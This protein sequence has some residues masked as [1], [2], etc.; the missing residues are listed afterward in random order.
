[1]PDSNIILASASKSRAMLLTGAGLD[2][3]IHPADIDEMEI[4]ENFRRKGADITATAAALARQKAEKISRQWPEA[5][6]IGADQMLDCG[7]NWLDKPTDMAGAA[8][9][10]RLLRGTQ[11]E[12]VTSVSIVKS[13][14]EVWHQTD[15]GRLVMRKF[16]DAFLA[17]YLE[18]IGE[19]VLSSVGAYQLEGLGAQLFE[20]I[21]GDYF[22]ILGLQVLPV[23]EYLR[24]EGVIMV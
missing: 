13:E 18:R 19:D 11:H 6:V 5:Y 12:L 14:K 20:K 3:E 17:R 8:K 23:L 22:T 15:H 2:I 4:K 16:S 10:L 7:G 9:T 21:D 1:M 24:S